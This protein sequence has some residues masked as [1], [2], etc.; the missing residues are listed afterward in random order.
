[1][2]GVK[3]LGYGRYQSQLSTHLSTVVLCVSTRRQTDPGAMI[4]NN[5]NNNNVFI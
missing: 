3:F 2:G 5:N 4:I 1:M